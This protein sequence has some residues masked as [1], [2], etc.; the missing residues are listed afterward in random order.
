MLCFSLLHDGT[1]LLGQGRGVDAYVERGKTMGVPLLYPWA[2]RLGGL[3]FSAAGKH[4]TLPGDDARLQRDPNGLPIHGVRPSLLRWDV[5]PEAEGDALNAR[6]AWATP[7]LLE[8]FP[9]VHEVRLRVVIGAGSL[10]FATTVVA[11]GADTVPVSFGYHPYLAV[12]GGDRAQWRVSLGASRRLLLD[13]RNVP[14]G[15]RVP[16]EPRSFVLGDTSLD[17]GYDELDEPAVFRA[18]SDGAGLEVDFR[19]GYRYAQA[20]T[21]PAVDAIC[22][23]PMTAPANALRSGDGLSVVDPGGSYEAVFTVALV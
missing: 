19:A 23:E 4:V 7:E 13:E 16:L 5:D 15:E 11:T 1:E 21:P 14:T 12:P 2:N 22:F 20:F 3:E 17:D 9:F 18:A 8:L 6:L 10:T